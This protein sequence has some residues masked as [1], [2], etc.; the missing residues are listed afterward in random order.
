LLEQQMDP[1]GRVLLP[2]P[3][4]RCVDRFGTTRKVNQQ[5]GRLGAGQPLAIGKFRTTGHLESKG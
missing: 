2:K 3:G 5:L 4:N 1:L